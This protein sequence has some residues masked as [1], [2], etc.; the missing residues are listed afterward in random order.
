MQALSNLNLARLRAMRGMTQRE[1]AERVGGG[2]TQETISLYENGRQKPLPENLI[3][4][5]DALGCT[6][7]ELVRRDG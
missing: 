1:L 5:A 4:L 6:I 7:D 2:M 3:R